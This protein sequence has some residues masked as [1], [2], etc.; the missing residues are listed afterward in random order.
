MI[1][2]C[3]ALAVVLGGTGHAAVA[4]PAN[5]VGTAQLKATAVTGEGQG[6]LAG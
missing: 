6:R 3:V 2:S 5:S 4:L 1:V